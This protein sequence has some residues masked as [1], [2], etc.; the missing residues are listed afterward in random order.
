MPGAWLP[1]RGSTA[2]QI[3]RAMG[4]NLSSKPEKPWLVFSMTAMTSSAI[5][6]SVVKSRTM[7]ASA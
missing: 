3:A 5:V 7:S 4:Q 6:S 1:K 2:S